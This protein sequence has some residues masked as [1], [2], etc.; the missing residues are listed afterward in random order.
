MKLTIKNCMYMFGEIWK[1]SKARIILTFVLALADGI[2]IFLTTF[3]LKFVIDAIMQNKPFYYIVVI[4]SIRLGY[5]L[6]YQSLDNILHT[7]IFPKLEN[8]IRKGITLKLY[9]KI[10]Y[11][12]MID[13]ENPELYDKITRAINEADN[14]AIWMLGTLRGLLSSTTQMIVL[15]VTLL[16]LSPFSILIAIVG[17]LVTF[18]ANVINSKKAYSFEIEKTKIN[19]KFDYIKRIFYLP[20]YKTDIHITNLSKV[21]E[22]KYSGNITCMNKTIN[23][24]TPS[25]AGIAI[26]ASWLFNFLN[27]GVSSIYVSKQIY[28][29]MMTVGDFTS[30]INA[31]NNLS[32]NFLQY[33]NIL[34]E[35]KR[36]ALFIEN[37]IEVLNMESEIYCKKGSLAVF[38]EDIEN[39]NL[40]SIYF[41][42]PNS[43]NV[44]KDI[45]LNL[46]RGQKIAFVGENGAGKSTLLNIIASLYRPNKGLIKVNKTLYD[47]INIKS[48][49]N[50]IAF[51]P[52]DF[53]T[54]AFSLKDNICLSSDDSFNIERI[55]EVIQLIG[56]KEKVSSL[57]KGLETQLSTEFDDE[58]VHFSG[59]E[60]QKLAI[61]RALYQN[62]QI[63]IMD[64][65]SSSLDPKSEEEIYKLIDNI[66]EKKTVI[67]VSH[68]MSCVKNMDA[69]YYIDNGEIIEYGSHFELMNLNGKYAETFKLQAKR[70]GDA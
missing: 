62:A 23:K 44:L 10:P 29:G 3:F 28:R 41:K 59:G 48:F 63:L 58:G 56:L 69:I 7:I 30:V 18:W 33:S 67:V 40:K 55:W 51:V 14:R 9:Q 19:R 53:Q 54:Y 35:F 25:I 65:P 66:S 8:N 22:R 50:N 15:F 70:Y 42:Y 21:L 12:D 27:I 60:S 43:N 57:D 5:L 37:Y 2:N 24:H 34:P 46:K 16:I 1:H 31:I 38:N 26:S 6:L 13:Y 61:A 39:I 32:N 49:Y 64:E 68:R 4:V 52:Q 17:T 11:I 47:D 36:H 45:N 20:Q